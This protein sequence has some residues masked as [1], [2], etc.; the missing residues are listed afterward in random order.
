M[1]AEWNV[2]RYKHQKKNDAKVK[3]ARWEE[4]WEKVFNNIVTMKCEVEQLKP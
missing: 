3:I 4:G 2:K 1:I